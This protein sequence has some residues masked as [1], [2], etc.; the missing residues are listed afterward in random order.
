[1]DE[2]S[3]INALIDVPRITP[4]AWLQYS[5][6]GYI[7]LWEDTNIC[8]IILLWAFL[9]KKRVMHTDVDCVRFHCTNKMFATDRWCLAIKKHVVM[10]LNTSNNNVFGGHIM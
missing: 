8:G 10:F 9:S 3:L 5:I 2:M 4:F 1:M 7:F 6:S